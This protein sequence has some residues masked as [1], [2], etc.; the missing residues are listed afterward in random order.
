MH[1]ASNNKIPDKEAVER[2][3]G[4]RSQ[5]FYSVNLMVG[6]TPLG[7]CLLKDIS[8]KG[9]R[10]CV[11]R[12]AWVPT[13]FRLE[14]P[15]GEFVLFVRQVWRKNGEIGLR[16]TDTPQLDKKNSSANNT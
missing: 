2:R 12:F 3:Q 4:P 8:S 10:I 14:C 15:Q 11:D 9:A 1:G 13:H 7:K 16:F 6:N 5:L